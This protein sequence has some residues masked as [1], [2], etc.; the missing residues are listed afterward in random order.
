MSETQSILSMRL[1]RGLPFS[2]ELKSEKPGDG[3]R[4]Y[5]QHSQHAPKVT[6]DITDAEVHRRT[7]FKTRDH[8][9]TYVSVV[10]NGDISKIMMRS[11]VLTWFEEWFAR[12][13][14]LKAEYGPS[15]M[16][17]RKMIQDK[18]SLEV[19]ARDRWPTYVSHEEDC[20]LRKSKW[21]EKYGKFDDKKS[22]RVV[23]WDMTNI[24]ACAFS[25]PNMNRI[26]QRPQYES[27]HIQCLLCYELLQGRRLCSAVWM[28]GHCSAVD[29]SCE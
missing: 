26:T 7:G 18:Y 21:D 13:I 19:G 1:R 20:K 22:L 27:D 23:M 11:T 9:L 28:D 8:L 2:F 14:D 10:C 29:W 6:L 17:L 12:L 24:P 25:D 4:T 15:V 16:D 5:S 3:K